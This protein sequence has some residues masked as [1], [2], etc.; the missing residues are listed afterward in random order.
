[1]RKESG[2][3]NEKELTEQEINCI[4]H[5]YFES[6]L[7]IYELGKKYKLTRRTLPLILKNNGIDTHR[8][9]RYTLNETY[10]HEIN[11]EEKAYWLGFL[12]ADGYVGNEKFNNII[13]SQKKSD[14][15]TVIQFAKDIDYSGK[16]REANPGDQSFENSQPQIVCN[17]SS[18]QMATDLRELKMYPNKSLTMSDMPLIDEKLIRHFCRGYFDGDG[19]IYEHV[20]SYY[21]NHVYK[22]Y[23]VSIIGTI[24]FLTKMQ[25]AFPVKSVLHDSHTPEMKYLQVVKNESIVSL[26][27]YFYKDATRFL[28]RKKDI[29]IKAIGYNHG[30]PWFEKWDKLIKGV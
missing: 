25:K 17:F 16:L 15:N 14:A 24:P 19:S 23:V 6:S 18:K 20:R 4:I 11:T 3:R 27:Y 21:K 28:Q 2:V 12:Y 13:F 30:K 10:F 9:N 8:K 7:T 1:M 22:Q 29:F 5:D 26:Y